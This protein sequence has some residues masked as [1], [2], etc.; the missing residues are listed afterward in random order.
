MTSRRGTPTTPFIPPLGSPGDPAS[1]PVI[2]NSGG[3]PSWNPT[4]YAPPPGASPYH[5]TPFIPHLS[6]AALGPPVIPGVMPPP[7]PQHQRS[8]S[9]GQP[10]GVSSDY[11]GYP[12]GTPYYGPSTA[13][14]GSYTPAAPPISPAWGYPSSAPAGFPAFGGTPWGAPGQNLPPQH[15]STPWGGPP[16]GLPP[17]AP[18]SAAFP[19]MPPL[20][21]AQGPY[22]PFPGMTQPGPPPGW[23][24]PQQP[25]WFQQQFQQ[26]HQPRGAPGGDW[27]IPSYFAPSQHPRG[28]PEPPAQI[29]DRMDPF[30]EG[31]HY[32]PVLEPFL[33]KVVGAQVKIN[34]LLQ[35]LPEDGSDQVHL[36]WNMIFPTSTVQRSLDPSHISWSKGRD[37]PAT[38]PRIT[39]MRLVSTAIP[40]MTNIKARNPEKGLTCGEVID[41]IGYDMSKFTSAQDFK[42]LSPTDQKEVTNAYR[43]HRS[44]SPG[45]PGGQLGQGMKRL[46]FLRQ[47]T[48]FAGIEV[49]DRMVKRICGEALPCVFVL[50]CS[51]TFPMTKQE[52]KDR[53]ARAKATS[54]GRRSRANSTSTRITVQ[55][56]SESGDSGD[57]D[58][59]R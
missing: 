26:P 34:P 10:P 22:T 53:E 14:P 11:T 19:G 38:F 58:T 6:P 47:N 35:P 2:P 20:H 25:P 30:A 9:R 52:I 50:K 3:S 31:S 23:G 15:H 45:V 1:A 43:H 51:P 36:K 57:A 18:Y 27:G 48:M 8:S 32:G 4:S 55:S 24:Q 39:A 37:T 13:L 12:Q 7:G 59:D 17:A 54:A 21:A 46:D 28:P 33:V 41:A 16:S 42:V 56:P 44:R 40:W 29:A 49:N 5:G